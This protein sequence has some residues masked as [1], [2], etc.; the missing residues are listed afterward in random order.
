MHYSN[1][2]IRPL[3]CET[4]N[5]MRINRIG[6]EA[7]CDLITLCSGKLWNQSSCCLDNLQAACGILKQA[8][9]WR[10]TDVVEVAPVPLQRKSEACCQALRVDKMMPD[11]A[12]RK[13]ENR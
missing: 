7:C 9:A 13:E 6:H 3:L 8:D 1:I 12:K 11:S 2:Q 4:N 5:R 10:Q